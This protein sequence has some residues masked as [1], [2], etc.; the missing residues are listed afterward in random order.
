MHPMP[1]R[2]AK[3]TNFGRRA[4]PM[5]AG[6]RLTE[7]VKFGKV[8]R[9]TLN[10]LSRIVSG[11]PCEVGYKHQYQQNVKHRFN[12]WVPRYNKNNYINV[13]EIDLLHI[14]SYVGLYCG[15]QTVPKIQH[16]NNKYDY[17]NK[18]VLHTLL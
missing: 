12:K 16:N 17:I 11:R 8:Y 3:R 14:I 6:G 4:E 2:R 13:C 1:G 15:A 7:R 18:H 9:W 10:E 5:M